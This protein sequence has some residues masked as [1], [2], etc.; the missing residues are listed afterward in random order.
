MFDSVFNGL[1]AETRRVSGIAT[2]AAEMPGLNAI[3]APAVDAFEFS[4]PSQSATDQYAVWIR[5][6]LDV[7]GPDGQLIVRW[8]ITAY[9]QSG[10]GGFSDEES[11]E[12]AAVLALRDAAA[13]IAT[14][15]SRQPKIR[16][17]L[18]K[19]SPQDGS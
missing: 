13:T 1:F 19:E 4:L 14:S 7:Y 11:M 9:G 12:R 3:V 6:N 15:F 2:A 18:L 8:P 16:E 5:Y 10:T 17:S